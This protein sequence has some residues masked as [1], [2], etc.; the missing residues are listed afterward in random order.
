MSW[1]SEALIISA[2]QFSGRRCQDCW[3]PQHPVRQAG[4]ALQHRHQAFPRYQ[5]GIRPLPEGRGHP[6]DRQVQGHSR[7]TQTSG[8]ITDK[9]PFLLPLLYSV[10]RWSTFPE[11]YERPKSCFSF[12]DN[13]GGPELETADYQPRD[14]GLSTT[15]RV[16][17]PI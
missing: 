2:N 4:E 9:P 16:D 3:W 8:L 13:T 15:R 11:F 6:R 12:F 5:Q 17:D 10:I 1:L 14:G 7:C